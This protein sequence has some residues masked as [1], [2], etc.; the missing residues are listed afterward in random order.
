MIDP[1]DKIAYPLIGILSKNPF[2]ICTFP[3][4]APVA[5]F[6]FSHDNGKFVRKKSTAHSNAITVMNHLT[7][8]NIEGCHD[9]QP[10][11][12]I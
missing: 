12:E 2:V 3:I 7:G 8:S 10:T 4:G 5:E 6:H 11:P 9:K 1:S